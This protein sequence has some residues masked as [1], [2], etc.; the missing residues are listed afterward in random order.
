MTIYVPYRPHDV[1]QHT[2]FSYLC[3]V[4]PTPII[5]QK[6]NITHEAADNAY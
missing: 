6:I 3:T 2:E 1:Q 4:L 5:Y